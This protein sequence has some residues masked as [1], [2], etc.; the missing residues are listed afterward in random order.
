MDEVVK[1]LLQA[2]I[3]AG[4]AAGAGYFGV[5]FGLSKFRGEKAMEARLDCYRRAT[6]HYAKLKWEIEVART[7][8]EEGGEDWG[9]HW[10]R[11]REEGYIPLTL[12][13]V[14]ARLFAS[15]TAVEV[16][17]RLGD[18]FDQ[19]SEQTDCFDPP[20]MEQ[21][22]N[23]GAAVALREN[24]DETMETLAQDVRR[25]LRFENLPYKKV[26]SAGP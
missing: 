8:T 1:I 22:Q 15:P 16:V 6:N 24:L 17:A 19:V 14:E 10:I 9:R 11:V 13:E 7:F 25:Q 21:D 3:A 20:S 23:L 5:V 2:L 12:L 26:E 18:A 4:A